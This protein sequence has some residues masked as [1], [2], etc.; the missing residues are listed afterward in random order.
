MILNWWDRCRFGGLVGS[1]QV[2]EMNVF[3][4]KWSRRVGWNEEDIHT[5]VD[6]GMK[7]GEG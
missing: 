7:L 4:Q 2:P 1:L 5:G 3:A 6:K